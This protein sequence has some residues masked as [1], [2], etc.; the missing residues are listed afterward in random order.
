MSGWLLR[1]LLRLPTLPTLPP[2]S[3][4]KEAAKGAAAGALLLPRRRSN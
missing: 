1:L 2:P 4:S 3:R